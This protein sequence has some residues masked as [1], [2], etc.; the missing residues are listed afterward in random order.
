MEKKIHVL[1]VDDETDFLEPMA[2]WLESKGY[3]VVVATNGE[4][5]IEVIKK[6]SP[7]IVFM[8]IYLPGMSGIDTLRQVRTFDKELPIV[9][10]TAYADEENI[11]LAQQLGA[12]GF[13]PKKESLE[14]FGRTLEVTLRTHRKLRP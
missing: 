12:S 9:M 13:F 4:E 10:I 5:A 1:L 2:F 11:S 7:D 8:D 14:E 3:S 6:E